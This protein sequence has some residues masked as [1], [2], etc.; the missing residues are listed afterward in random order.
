MQ[1]SI[2]PIAALLLT[3]VAGSYRGLM[4]RLPG[5][6]ETSCGVSEAPFGNAEPFPGIMRAFP[7]TTENLIPSALVVSAR[8]RC[9]RLAHL[10]LHDCREFAYHSAAPETGR[11]SGVGRCRGVRGVC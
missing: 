3:T 11:A 7:S 5:V 10:R 4:E 8:P 6:A 2:F 1:R 9:S